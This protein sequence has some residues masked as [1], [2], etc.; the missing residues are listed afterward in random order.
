MAFASTFAITISA[1]GP[2][3]YISGGAEN[4]G[5]DPDYPGDYDVYEVVY[6][7]ISN[8]KYRVDPPWWCPLCGPCYYD[9]PAGIYFEFR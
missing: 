1:E 9:V 5:D 7:R 2:S 3:V 8:Y 6:V 4:E